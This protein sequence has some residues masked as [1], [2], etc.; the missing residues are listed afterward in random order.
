MHFMVGPQKPNRIVDIF[1]KIPMSSDFIFVSSSSH[2]RSLTHPFANRLAF[3]CNYKLYKQQI[4]NWAI[5]SSFLQHI[6]GDLPFHGCVDAEVNYVPLWSIPV[7]AKKA[8]INETH[9]VSYNF[10]SLI[11]SRC[12]CRNSCN[13]RKTGFRRRW[14]CILVVNKTSPVMDNFVLMSWVC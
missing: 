14:E 9:F 7:I 12:L 1:Q 10:V 4:C 5:F 6:S 2:F 3:S 11:R 13:L 8:E